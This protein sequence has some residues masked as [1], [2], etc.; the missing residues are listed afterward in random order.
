MMQEGVYDD[1][2]DEMDAA[3]LEDYFNA[4]NPQGIQG[5]VPPAIDHQARRIEEEQ[6]ANIRHD[7]I[8]VPANETPFP[9]AEIHAVFCTALDAVREKGILPSR[10]GIRADKW[11]EGY[12]TS[13]VIQR[14]R[15]GTREQVMSLPVE[16]WRPRAER[17][18]QG[19]SVMLSV[20]DLV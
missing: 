15:R 4:R 11:D 10:L 20:L 6:Q 16:I 12:P 13:E 1:D 18:C 8:D 9:Q 7:A 17:W 14:G 5:D 19:L 2:H 3:T